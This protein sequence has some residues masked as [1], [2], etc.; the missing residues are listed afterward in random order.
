MN[1]IDVNENW[2]IG[3]N[4]HTDSYILNYTTMYACNFY[5]LSETKDIKVHLI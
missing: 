2:Y 3:G 5:I 1:N 4:N